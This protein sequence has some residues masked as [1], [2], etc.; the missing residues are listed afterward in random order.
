MSEVI[1]GSCPKRIEQNCPKRIEGV[2][3]D[4]H[5]TPEQCRGVST[6]QDGED[7]EELG[8]KMLIC[9][10]RRMEYG[11]WGGEAWLRMGDR[12]PRRG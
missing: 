2:D 8:G 3:G 9:T 7:G 11:D 4:V 5:N 6:K 10:R 12:G 1:E